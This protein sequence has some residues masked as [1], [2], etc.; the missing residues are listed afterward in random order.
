MWAQ[1]TD[2]LAKLRNRN[3]KGYEEERSEPPEPFAFV[4]RVF[5][6]D[7]FRDALVLS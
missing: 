5:A 2:R 3:L 6:S 4:S 1:N 7:N